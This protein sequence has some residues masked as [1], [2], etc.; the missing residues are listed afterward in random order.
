M[1]EKLNIFVSSLKDFG[2]G[3]LQRKNQ[4]FYHDFQAKIQ[5]N[6]YSDFFVQK[7]KNNNKMNNLAKNWTVGSV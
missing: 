2:C 4:N 7:F 5:N 3:K 1:C 6:N